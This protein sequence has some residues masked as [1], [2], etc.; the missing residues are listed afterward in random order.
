[1]CTSVDSY[2][3][4]SYYGGPSHE[5]PYCGA[6]FW[7]QER[8]KTLSLVSK[9]KIVYNP[10]YRGAKIN[11]KPYAKPAAP[12]AELL[13]FDG[14]SQS[15]KFLRQIR[16]YNSMFVFTSIGASVDKTLNNGTAPYVFKKMGLFTIV[17]VPC[18][19]KVVHA[20]NLHSFT[21]T[22]QNTNQATV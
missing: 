10:C 18:C 9:R 2:K 3:E 19:P 5:C 8:A 11:L 20:Q 22:I 1:M 7:S 14:D 6:F 4:R 21:Y 13:R 15:R 16:S 17:L 12:L